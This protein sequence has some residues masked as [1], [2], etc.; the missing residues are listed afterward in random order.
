MISCISYGS[1]FQRIK[2]LSLRSLKNCGTLLKSNVVDTSSVNRLFEE[3]LLQFGIEWK[4]LV[5]HTPQENGVAEHKNQALVQM[6]RC[7]L[8]DKY[9]PPQ[10]WVEA[11]YCA[12]YFLNYIST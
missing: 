8:Q 10:F 7:L 9:F 4:R 12:N 6:A 5:L 2:I 1:F 11:S 3:Y